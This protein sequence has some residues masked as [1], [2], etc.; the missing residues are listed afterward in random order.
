MFER[1]ACCNPV[2]NARLFI[3][4]DLHVRGRRRNLDI[5][6]VNSPLKAVC[7]KAYESRSIRICSREPI[8]VLHR[9]KE[10]AAMQQIDLFG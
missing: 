2:I 8:S 5:E 9:T 6:H 3:Q 4:N 10:R 7:F 1:Q